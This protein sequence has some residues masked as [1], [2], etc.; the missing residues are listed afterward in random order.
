[1]LL[2]VAGYLL[3]SVPAGYLAVRWKKG[4]DIR[5][6]GSG[7]IGATNVGRILGRKWS[8]AVAAFDMV[9]GGIVLVAGMASGVTDPLILG[10]SGFTAV[11]GHDYPFW[12]RFRGGKGISTSYGVV[13][14]LNPVAALGAAAVWYATLKMSRYV[15]VASMVS[16]WSMPVFMVLL[17]APAAYVVSCAALAALAVLRHSGNIKNILEG[18]EAKTGS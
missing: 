9:K 7:N 1:L 13:F 17:A 18:T 2:V 11:I 16:L 5:T 8:I 14:V 12:L 3:G 4:I 15:S 10:L 6:F